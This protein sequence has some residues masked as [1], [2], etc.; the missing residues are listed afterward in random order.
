MSN[1]MF[2]IICIAV[3]DLTE[4]LSFYLLLISC[5]KPRYQAP[6]KYLLFAVHFAVTC[7]CGTPLLLAV[8]ERMILLPV[9]ILLALLFTEGSALKRIFWGGS[10]TILSVVAEN[11]AVLAMEYV[12]LL[13]PAQSVT[14][15]AA[16]LTE[17]LLYLFFCLASV[18]VIRITAAYTAALPVRILLIFLGL[19][20]S[21]FLSLR[22]FLQIR[23]LVPLSGQNAPSLQDTIFQAGLIQI[24]L[25]LFFFAS[26]VYLG[27]L[28]RKNLLLLEK[29]KISEIERNRLHALQSANQ[30]LRV[31]KHE[32]DNHL[33]TCCQ[34]LE[35]G[36]DRDCIRYLH[37][38]LETADLSRRD[39]R[40]GNSVLDAVL[41]SRLGDAAGRQIRIQNQIILPDSLKFPVG[42]TEL[43]AILCCALDNAAEAC[44]KLPAA[45]R[46]IC[47]T[48]KLLKSTLMIQIENS[49][50]G[51]YQQD[52]DGMPATTKEENKAEHG[53]G[54]RR[55]A[56]IAEKAGGFLKILPEK[57]RFTLCVLLPLEDGNSV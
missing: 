23:A 48:I 17:V 14:S 13:I 51:I 9:Q 46:Y 44:M 38:L 20:F 22:L 41:S 28:Y 31:W 50:D 54:L 36:K 42:D 57:D 16:Y 3:I 29:D 25:I 4:S 18:L 55:I 35:N 11:L 1:S 15:R 24:F 12:T 53:I 45:E 32:A 6:R 8:P 30:S 2:H 52:G 5:L 56:D 39:I 27:F 49:S 33:I 19:I 37:S 47:T 43:S 7:L 26:A 34:L 40:T 10:F 21:G